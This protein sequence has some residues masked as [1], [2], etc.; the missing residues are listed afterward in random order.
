MSI[1]Q[2]TQTIH[3]VPS[4]QS[5][6]ARRPL[7]PVLPGLE[8]EQPAAQVSNRDIAEVLANI[9]NL[10]AFQ[11]GNPYRV[12]AYRNAARGVLELSEQAADIL[13]RGEELPIPGLGYRLRARIKE[14]VNGGS[15]TFHDGICLETLPPDVRRLMQ[16]EHVGPIT[17]IRLHEELGVD[18]LD[19]MRWAAQNQRI[20]KLPGFGPRSEARIKEA[21]DHLLQTRQSEPL[22]GAA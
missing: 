17:A 2:L 7:Q 4:A 10:L 16:V 11:H 14:L 5:R 9:A 22:H 12:Q 18:T 3:I 21:V 15:M 13:E 19:K 1:M 20:R 6:P 8:P